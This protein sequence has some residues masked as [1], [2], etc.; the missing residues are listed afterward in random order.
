MQGKGTMKQIFKVPLKTLDKLSASAQVTQT[1]GWREVSGIYTVT[2]TSLKGGFQNWL[3][4]FQG[5]RSL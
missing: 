4:T 1:I 2:L 3:K 5:K